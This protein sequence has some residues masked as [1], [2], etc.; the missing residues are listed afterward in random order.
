MTIHLRR[1]FTLFFQKFLQKGIY[2]SVHAASAASDMMMETKILMNLA[3][4]PNICQ[5]YGVTAAGSD[6]FLSRG[7]EGFYIILDRLSGTMIQQIKKWREEQEKEIALRRSKGEEEKS[8]ALNEYQKLMQRLEV[9]LDI[10]SALLFLSDRQIVFH[11]RPDKVGFDV[12]YNRIKLCDFGQ[13]RENGQLDQAPSLT[14]TDDIRTLAYT[15][16]EVLC[17]APVTVAAD[18]YAY[19]VVLWEMLTLQRPFEGMSRSEH[20][21]S[22]IMDS[23]RPPLLPIIPKQVQTLIE[24]CWDPHL[25]PTMKKVYDSVEE[26]LLFQEDKPDVAILP[27]P[28]SATAPPSLSRA[29]SEMLTNSED[30]PAQSTKSGR[31]PLRR[32]KTADAQARPVKRSVKRE[33]HQG[34]DGDD[35]PMKDKSKGSNHEGGSGQRTSRRSRRSTTSSGHEKSSNHDSMRDKSG[36]MEDSSQLVDESKDSHGPIKDKSKTRSSRRSRAS[37]SKKTSEEASVGTKTSD[38]HASGDDIAGSEEGR[39]SGSK[40]KPPAFGRSATAE[41]M[42]PR[43]APSRST[44]TSKTPGF[45]RS[46]TTTAAKSSRSKR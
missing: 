32:N 36:K 15:A 26:V 33:Q 19:G 8:I 38:S 27:L 14:K 17:Q 34:G 7:K 43:A 42:A 40:K 11:L 35:G 20:F 9:A 25:R 24:K 37:T 6:A 21:E 18:V 13:A 4:H 22:V 16:P 10:G 45:G 44:S 31:K 46:A 39:E 12:R 5:I 2:N 1:F 3:P 29:A 28:A 41:N 30:E 23:Q